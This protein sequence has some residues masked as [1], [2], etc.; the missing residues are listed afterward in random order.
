M[1]EREKLKKLGKSKTKEELALEDQEL[2]K[3]DAEESKQAASGPGFGFIS[4]DKQ[5]EFA[6]EFLKQIKN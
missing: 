6:Q 2:K 1:S 3:I 5:A 4:Q